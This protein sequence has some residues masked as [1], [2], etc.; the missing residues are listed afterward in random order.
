MVLQTERGASCERGSVGVD[1]GVAAVHSAIRV[2]VAVDVDVDVNGIA[3]AESVLEAANFVEIFASLDNGVNRLDGLDG[4]LGF[5]DVKDAVG[6][7]PFIQARI[8]E[9]VPGGATVASVLLLS[10]GTFVERG[11]GI[12]HNDGLLNDDGLL[13]DS[14]LDHND[15]LFDNKP[16]VITITKVLKEAALGSADVGD[17]LVV[18]GTVDT[19]ENTV[20]LGLGDAVSLLLGGGAGVDVGDVVGDFGDEAEVSER[21]SA[22]DASLGLAEV[23]EAVEA[24]VVELGALSV[25]LA[26]K[27]GGGGEVLH[28]V[29]CLLL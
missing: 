27:E 6:V 28:I 24:D 7:K 16:F 23:E 4:L 12:D 11:N 25:I 26:A 9:R 1:D 18:L 19:G 15:G 3:R 5:A 21:V 13:D 2:A 22:V 10:R 14:G 20:G 8:S 17:T 29:Y